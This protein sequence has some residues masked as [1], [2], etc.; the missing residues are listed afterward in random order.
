[1]PTQLE[2]FQER[3]KRI[4]GWTSDRE[5]SAESYYND[6]KILLDFVHELEE[7]TSQN[8]EVCIICN[9]PGDEGH[10][11]ACP[12]NMLLR[13]YTG[14]TYTLQR[15]DTK[16]GAWEEP[17]RSM[18]D[19]DN[20]IPVEKSPGFS[21]YVGPKK[22]TSGPSVTAHRA[23]AGGAPPFKI[24]EDGGLGLMEITGAASVVASVKERYIKGGWEILGETTEPN[25][26]VH[27]TM[28][29]DGELLRP[30]VAAVKAEQREAEL[31]LQSTGTGSQV[32]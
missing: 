18:P 7:L 12:W 15:R 5:V 25:G 29:I 4:S 1:M 22:R 26:H 19:R 17:D 28:M 3:L 20:P 13:K 30:F 11:E 10:T 32:G 23:S 9:T 31:R 6:V 14:Y 27:M 8:A 24:W 2:V 16:K 21:G